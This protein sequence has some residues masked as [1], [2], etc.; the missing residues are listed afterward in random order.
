ML[1]QDD[2][3]RKSGSLAGLARKKAVVSSQL[4]VV[5]RSRSLAVLVMTNEKSRS[6]AVLVMT[7]QETADRSRAEARS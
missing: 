3:S 2:K 5:R 1:A 7:N 6:L 4:S